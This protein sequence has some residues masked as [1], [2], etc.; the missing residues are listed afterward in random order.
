M[1][2]QAHARDL[3]AVSETM[4][5]TLYS[6]AL[7]SRRPDGLIRDPRA[8][9][10]V[11]RIDYDF[12]GRQMGADDQAASCLRLRQFDRFA[13]AFLAAHPDSVVVHVGCGLDTRFDRVDNGR[14]EWYD[15]D[16]PEVIEL[17]R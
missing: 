3:S 16:L 13:Q 1:P 14:V 2:T 4:L 7:E 15:L 8:E 10:L 6:H 5:A 11:A 17:R 12:A 9:E